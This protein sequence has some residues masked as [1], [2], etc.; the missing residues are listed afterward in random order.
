MSNTDTTLVVL[1]LNR[2]EALDLRREQKDHGGARLEEASVD[3]SAA[4]V[5]DPV[6]LAIVGGFLA[7]QGLVAWLLKN[8]HE[9]Y[10]H[11]DIEIRRPDGTVERRQIT[12]R[13]KDSTLAAETAQVIAALQ[14]P[15][16]GP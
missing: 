12:V 1:N 7:V 15:N 10:I 3:T 6:S 5:L 11:Q 9:D 14:L 2:A 13:R 8:R 16:V 4:G